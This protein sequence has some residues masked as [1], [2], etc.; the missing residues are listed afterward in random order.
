MNFKSPVYKLFLAILSRKPGL[1]TMTFGACEVN[2]SISSCLHQNGSAGNAHDAVQ[3]GLLVVWQL[4]ILQAS[5]TVLSSDVIRELRV[6]I[7]CTA[8][9]GVQLHAYG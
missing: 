6:L 1:R 9:T 7:T 5:L 2:A 8:V 4:A 3:A